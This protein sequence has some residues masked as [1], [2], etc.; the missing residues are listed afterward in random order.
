MQASI[1]MAGETVGSECQGYV[2]VPVSTLQRD[3]ITTFD[4]YIRARAGEA[5]V[6]Y[7][8]ADLPF[9]QEA[10]N[11]LRERKV[12][13]VWIRSD[14]GTL[15]RGYVEK[16]IGVI[17]ADRSIPVEHRSA[18]LY[19]SAQSLVQE[20]LADPRSGELL[21][22]SA[23]MVLHMVRFMFDEG[24]SFQALMRVTSF[25]YYTYTHCVDV[26]VYST[27][28]A[29]RLGFSEKEVREFGQGALLH[30]V[31][32]SLIDPE[33][34]NCR[35]K[36]SDD[37]WRVMKMHPIYG[38]E[39]L[40]EQGV[41]SQVVLD[42]TRHHHEKLTGAGYPDQLSNGQISPY[43]RIAAMTDV[44]CALTTRRPYKD[45]MSTFSSLQL[46]KEKMLEELD[47]ELFGTF[48]KLMALR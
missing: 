14:Q 38:Y 2:P 43:V 24:H 19:D 8:K 26:F 39:L 31:G 4:L 22:R 10:W 25:D 20:V 32:K 33:V 6:L 40:K 47:A 11:R 36:L 16:N 29:Q 21:Q 34:L 13:V 17:L 7:R 12:G 9:S 18:L 41:T 48:V 46:M 42:V 35:G 28:L 5:P 23:D 3:T 37:Q 27:A 1:F 44:F 30:D 45:A 15:Y